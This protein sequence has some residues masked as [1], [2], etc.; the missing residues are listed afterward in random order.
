MQE[1]AASD[2]MTLAAQDIRTIDEFKEWTRREIRPLLPHAALICGHGHIH[3]GGVGLD[4][5]VPIDYPVEYLEGIRNRSGGID[6]P[7]LRRWLVTREPVLFE[8]DA[9]W[10]DVPAAWLEC[11]H[12]YELKNAVAHAVYDV[13]RCVGTYHCFSR[14]PGRPGRAHLDAV[15]RLTPILHETLC[16]VMSLHNARSSF[17]TRLAE[18]SP[19][20][21]EITRWLQTG[22]SNSE[23]A[24]ISGLSE[25]TVKHHLTRIFS[26]LDVDS[27]SQLISRLSEDDI[28]LT[29]GFGTRIF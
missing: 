13:E 27:R 29:P 21:K 4:F 28:R 15:R 2:A 12:E 22:K 1:H 25:N 23:I 5:A 16:K 17:A 8:A 3:A 14:I 26:K 24:S 20:E 11:F 18:L 10:P 6:S 9:P 7:I 19:R